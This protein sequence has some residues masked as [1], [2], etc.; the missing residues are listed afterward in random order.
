MTLQHYIDLL[1]KAVTENPDNPTLPIGL[2][3]PHSWR[4]AYE[5]LSFEPK[6]QTNLKD[7]LEEAKACIGKTFS[8]HK[9]GQFTMK[10]ETPIHLDYAGK[11]SDEAQTWELLLLLMLQVGNPK[12]KAQTECQKIPEARKDPVITFSKAPNT[13]A[14]E[15]IDGAYDLIEVYKPEGAY[16]I[17]WRNAWLAKARE[18]G[19]CADW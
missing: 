2:G 5:E 19:A 6:P 16:N 4:G 10:A 13:A 12:T 3:N 11:W 1:E 7:M 18:L 8:G 15:L 17:Q 9:G 14:L